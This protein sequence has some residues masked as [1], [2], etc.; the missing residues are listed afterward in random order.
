VKRP[1]RRE[2]ISV[3]AEAQGHMMEL[4]AN[5][6][7]ITPHEV[8]ERHN[9]FSKEIGKVLDSEAPRNPA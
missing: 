1:S 4:A 9:R 6:S 5:L 2:L 7:T 8:I 3:L